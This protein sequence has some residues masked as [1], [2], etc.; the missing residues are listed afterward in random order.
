M[1]VFEVYSIGDCSAQST[2]AIASESTQLF[3][4]GAILRRCFSCNGARVCATVIGRKVSGKVIV[5]IDEKI[6]VTF[7]AAFKRREQP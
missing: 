3:L 2:F 4:A 6:L 1:I 5:D 7:G